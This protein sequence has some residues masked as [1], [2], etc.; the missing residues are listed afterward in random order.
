MVFRHTGL[1]GPGSAPVSL[2]CTLPCLVV[3]MPW[4][5]AEPLGGKPAWAWDAG[6]GQ[7]VC[8]GGRATEHWTRALE[9]DSV[10]LCC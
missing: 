5:S 6:R 2:S 9:L 7:P 1:A 4:E 10:C 8:G 3:A